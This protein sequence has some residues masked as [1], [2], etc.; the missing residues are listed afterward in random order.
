MSTDGDRLAR[1]TLASAKL[2]STL[3]HA[4]RGLLNG[5]W[6]GVLSDRSLEAVDARYYA[7]SG[8]YRT[9]D[10]NERGLFDWERRAVE[11]HFAPGG[12]VVVT[13]CG[14][15]REVL[16]LLEAGFDAHGREPHPELAAYANRFLAERGHPG[17]VAAS[18]RD[19][20][21]PG[22]ERLDG[23]VVGWGAYSLMHGGGT[24]RR[25][26]AAARAAL[27]EDAPVLISFFDRDQDR[28]ELRWTAAVANVLRRLR[29][30]P[31]RSRWATRSRRTSCTCSRE[32]SWRRR[33]GRRG[34]AWRP[35][36]SWGPPT[37]ASATRAP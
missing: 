23:V 28:R 3:A 30:A 11:D 18:E 29:G 22:A 9:A 25:F 33:W 2:P 10:W 34:S 20:F 19:E 27:E 36:A 8:V 7:E 26:L 24:R 12:R 21:P 14:G 17:R 15:G 6:L 37:R 5:F 1:L 31:N 13:A 4:S 16:G 35:T 32:R